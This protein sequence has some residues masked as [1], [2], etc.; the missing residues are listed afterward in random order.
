MTDIQTDTQTNKGTKKY[1]SIYLAT[2]KLTIFIQCDIYLLPTVSSLFLK[3]KICICSG[4]KTI[5]I[6]CITYLLW[7]SHSSVLQ[8]FVLKITMIVHHIAYTKIGK[9]DVNFSKHQYNKNAST[10]KITTNIWEDIYHIVKGIYFLKSL[11]NWV[12][13]LTWHEGVLF[14]QLSWP[15]DEQSQ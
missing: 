3:V 7:N 12:H 8:L 2:L 11:V 13:R 6:H 14:M 10:P 4:A 9:H 5:I 15:D 1:R